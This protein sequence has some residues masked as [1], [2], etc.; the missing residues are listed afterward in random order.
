VRKAR[1]PNDKLDRATDNMLAEADRKALHGLC[2]CHL[3]YGI[4]ECYVLIDTSE[5]APP[6][7]Q[8]A[9]GYSIYLSRRD[10]RLSFPRLPGNGTARSRTGDISITSPTS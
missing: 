5:R 10:G 6:L 7:P 9:S 1:E 8:P 2:R 3:P 4:T